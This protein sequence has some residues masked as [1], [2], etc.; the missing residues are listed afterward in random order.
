MTQ[1][2]D[3]EDAMYVL[4]RFGFAPRDAGLLASALVRPGATFAGAPLYGSLELQAAAL[5]ESLARNHALVDGNKRTAW[6]LTVL[7]LWL[8]GSAHDFDADAAFDLVLGVGQGRIVLEDSAAA[9][10]AHRIP[11][12]RPG[13]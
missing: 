1:F 6:T 8:N 13:T 11:L 12:G 4:D 10:A 9:I 7:F 5:L 2:L 3:L